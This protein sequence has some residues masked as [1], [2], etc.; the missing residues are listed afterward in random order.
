MFSEAEFRNPESRD[1][2]RFVE[3]KPTGHRSGDIPNQGI[4]VAVPEETAETVVA[5]ANAHG[6]L[7]FAGV[8]DDGTSAGYG[9]RE[10][11]IEGFESIPRRPPRPSGSCCADRLRIAAVKVLVT[12]SYPKSDATT[13]S[14]GFDNSSI[15]ASSRRNTSADV[16][17]TSPSERW[18]NRANVRNALGIVHTIRLRREHGPFPRCLRASKVTVER[19]NMLRIRLAE[20]KTFLYRTRT[21]HP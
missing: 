6:R 15:T 21:E 7:L 17:T 19:S 9:H 14:M 12:G 8:D 13:L 4:P 2:F 5:F 18:T 10:D 20:N 11:T 16:S 3:L 1:E